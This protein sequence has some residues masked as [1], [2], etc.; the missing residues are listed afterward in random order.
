M[1]QLHLYGTLFFFF[2]LRC[3]YTTTVWRPSGQKASRTIECKCAETKLLAA[4]KYRQ[5]SR[6]ISGFRQRIWLSSHHQDE[7]CLR[8]TTLPADAWFAARLLPK[9]FLFDSL[10]IL[11][12]NYSNKAENFGSFVIWNLLIHTNFSRFKASLLFN[13]ISFCK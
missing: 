2:F 9:F 3:R 8:I 13:T 10:A 11:E 6:S 1:S 4:H 5:I 12:P 7:F